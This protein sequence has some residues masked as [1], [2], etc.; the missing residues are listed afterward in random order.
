[1]YPV[2]M[3]PDERADYQAT[4][5]ASK[6]SEWNQQQEDGFMRGKRKIGKYFNLNSFL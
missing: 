2:D 5:S 3:N 4:C 6:A 1:M